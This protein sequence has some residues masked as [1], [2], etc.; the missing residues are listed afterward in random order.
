[1]GGQEIFKANIGLITDDGKFSLDVQ[2]LPNG[3][4]SLDGPHFFIQS[5]YKTTDW[6]TIIDAPKDTVP[7]TELMQKLDAIRPEQSFTEATL[8][9]QSDINI[10]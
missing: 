7:M 2:V 5:L 10:Q 9:V 1:M 3:T 8:P 6:N 4:G